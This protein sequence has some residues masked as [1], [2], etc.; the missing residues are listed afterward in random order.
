M[1]A[2]LQRVAASRVEVSGAVI[3]EIEQGILLFAGFQPQDDEAEVARQLERILNYRLFSDAADKMNLSLRDIDGGLL[4][5]PQFTLAA[6]TTRGRRPSFTAA[7]S[8]EKGEQLCNYSAK[9][10]HKNDLTGFLRISPDFSVTQR[11]PSNPCLTSIIVRS[12]AS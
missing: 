3:G 12:F 1:I 5:V 8:P 7:A 6:D 9:K 4:I 10:N 11:L 2:L